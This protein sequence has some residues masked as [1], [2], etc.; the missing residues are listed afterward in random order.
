MIQLSL[1]SEPLTLECQIDEVWAQS[2]KDKK[3][4]LELLVSWGVLGNGVLDEI[5]WSLDITTP[6]MST[7]QL[8][9]HFCRVPNICGVKF[10]RYKH[11]FRLISTLWHLDWAYLLTLRKWGQSWARRNKTR[12]TLKKN[13]NLCY[14]SSAWCSRGDKVSNYPPGWS[15][16][17]RA[18]LSWDIGYRLCC[19]GH[20]A[21]F[22]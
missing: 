4:V 10:P 19:F 15:R 9:A 14:C 20:N 12:R 13:Q 7:F 3:K 11:I 22:F 16:L 5:Q 2:E 21:I 6:D 18:K 8:Y 17:S 1:S